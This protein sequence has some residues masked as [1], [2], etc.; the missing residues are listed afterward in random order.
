MLHG[1]QALNILVDI[2]TV[3]NLSTEYRAIKIQL[4]NL[5]SMY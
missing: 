5:S 3:Q 2:K 4:I 1:S